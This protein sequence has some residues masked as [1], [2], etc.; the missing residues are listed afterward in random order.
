MNWKETLKKPETRERS[1]HGNQIRIVERASMT[2]RERELVMGE[3]LAQL[4]GI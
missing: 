3:S 2:D 1:Q 4:L